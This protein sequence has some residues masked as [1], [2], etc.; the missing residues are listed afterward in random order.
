MSVVSW[1]RECRI[2][3]LIISRSLE[4]FHGQP[5]DAHAQDKSFHRWSENDGHLGYKSEFRAFPRHQKKPV[6]AHLPPYPGR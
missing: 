5:A 2:Y 3:L 1:E 6:D 4:L